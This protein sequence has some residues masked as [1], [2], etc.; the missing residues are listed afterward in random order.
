MPRD[1]A[2]LPGFFFFYKL[3]LY[4]YAPTACFHVHG[5]HTHMHP[6]P[7]EAEMES[8]HWLKPNSGEQL[9]QI[10]AFDHLVMWTWKVTIW[11]IKCKWY[12]LNSLNVDCSGKQNKKMKQKSFLMK[13]CVIISPL[14]T[15]HAL[16]CH[17]EKKMYLVEKKFK[18]LLL[19]VFSSFFLMSF[20]WVV[21]ITVCVPSHKDWKQTRSLDFYSWMGRQVIK[22]S[23]SQSSQTITRRCRS[24]CYRVAH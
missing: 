2:E 12:C 11:L 4:N 1:K 23:K 19:G 22:G 6:P 14:R 3:Q 15:S 18:F 21:V 10:P 13:R 24:Y 5:T 7:A 20:T 8:P 17:R 16:V 9:N